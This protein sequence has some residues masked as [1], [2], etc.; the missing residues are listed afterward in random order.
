MPMHDRDDSFE[1]RRSSAPA[2]HDPYPL[3]HL[4]REDEEERRRDYLD[5]PLKDPIPLPEYR[6]PHVSPLDDH[7]R[8]GE[9]SPLLD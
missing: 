9:R 5:T 4:G 1:R 6:S 3:K 7:T 8:Y 2:I